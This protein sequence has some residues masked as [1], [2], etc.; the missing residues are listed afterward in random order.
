[1]TEHS[2]TVICPPKT[3]IH[4]SAQPG[5]QPTGAF[6]P[7][8]PPTPSTASPWKLLSTAWLFQDS[9]LKR[10]LLIWR[11]G[12]FDWASPTESHFLT[13]RKPRDQRSERH[14]KYLQDRWMRE[15]DLPP[16]CDHSKMCLRYGRHPSFIAKKWRRLNLSCYFQV[17]FKIILILQK[18]IHLHDVCIN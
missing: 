13:Y 9:Y 18:K 14:F 15:W 17:I 5:V 6:D 3:H 11:F 4:A 7:S 8:P 12:V 16:R 2:F 10:K 1:M